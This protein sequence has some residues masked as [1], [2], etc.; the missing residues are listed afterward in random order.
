MA[1]IAEECPFPIVMTALCREVFEIPLDWEEK[2]WCLHSTWD[3]HAYWKSRFTA[4]E[5]CVHPRRREYLTESYRTIAADAMRQA[6]HEVVKVEDKVE[7]LEQQLAIVHERLTALELLVL[8][9]RPQQS[10]TWVDTAQMPQPQVTSACDDASVVATC[11][12]LSESASNVPEL[13][14]RL[15]AELRIESCLLQSQRLMQPHSAVPTTRCGDS[16][17][18]IA[19]GELPWPLPPPS[20]MQGDNGY[21]D[22]GNGDNGDQILP[23]PRGTSSSSSSNTRIGLWLHSLSRDKSNQPAQEH[24]ASTQLHIS[25][26]H[27]E[28]IAS[29][30]DHTGTFWCSYQSG[31]LSHGGFSSGERSGAQRAGYQFLAPPVVTSGDGESVTV[32]CFQTRLLRC[33]RT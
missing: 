23:P 24:V 11:G 17:S 9:A 13:L 21:G 10:S 27:Q 3:G 26:S 22:N 28:E 4:E 31:V 7:V 30:I 2:R 32:A 25:T 29:A 16:G 33:G 5:K 15:G 20:R 18:R 14:G 1:F 12:Q 19:D 8:G 6:N